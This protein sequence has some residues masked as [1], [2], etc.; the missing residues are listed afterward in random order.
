VRWSPPSCDGPTTVASFFC[1]AR[2]A[3]IPYALT[4]DPDTGAFRSAAGPSGFASYRE[5]VEASRFL[6]RGQG[7]TSSLTDS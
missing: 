7:L 2:A 5:A 4:W 1:L 6:E 3:W